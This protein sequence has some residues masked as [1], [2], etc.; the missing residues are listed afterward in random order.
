[1][2][3]SFFFFFFE[4]GKNAKRDSISGLKLNISCTNCKKRVFN[5][6]YDLIQHHIFWAIPLGGWEIDDIHI[7]CVKCGSIYSL[8]AKADKEAE[9]LYWKLKEQGA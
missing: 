4:W 2:G 1:M 7:Q 8:D 3:F 9:D 6:H 5:V